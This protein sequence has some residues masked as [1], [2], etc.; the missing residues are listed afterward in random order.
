MEACKFLSQTFLFK[1]MSEDAIY[2]AI[3]SME[4]TV[5][6]YSRTD[7]ID[8]CEI[9]KVGFLISGRL[10]VVRLRSDG[11]NTVLNQLSVGD[12][13]G[14]LSV[15]SEEEC[16]T[17]IYATKNSEVL[18][19]TREQIMFFVNSSSQISVNLI[20]FLANRISFLNKKIET[21]SGAHVENR[22]AS[23]ILQEAGKSS[24]DEFTFNRKKC[25]EAINSG[26]ASVYR[27]LSSLESARLITVAD[28]KIIINDREGLERIKK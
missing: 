19:F 22:L 26:R 25:S 15:L 8:P 4:P 11:S 2:D 12:S 21:F 7:I 5:V 27:A 24:S 1:G 10:E 16:N 20:N 6:K 28:K 9:K 13:F 23:Y 18:Y 3:G 17:K 14:I